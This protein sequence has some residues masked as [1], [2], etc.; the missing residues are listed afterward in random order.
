MALITLTSDLGTRDPYL[1]TVKGR[2][3]RH[4]PDLV[5]VD[6]THHVRPNEMPM[7]AWAL[8]QAYPAFAPD[9]IHWVGV[10]S[11]YVKNQRD[12]VVYHHGQYFVGPDDGLFALLFDE[13]PEFIFAIQQGI[14]SSMGLGGIYA[15]T[16]LAAAH[17][18]RGGEI[19]DIA[20]QVKG[21]AE[22]N[23]IRPHQGSD[24]IRG[25][26]I[27]VDHFGNLMLNIHRDMMEQVG[28]G[29]PMRIR[30][31]ARYQVERIRERYSDVPAGDVLARYN[32]GGYLEI[33]INRGNARDMFNL[34]LHDLVQVQFEE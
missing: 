8:R 2:L 30:F 4:S 31:R 25:T 15:D 10:D 20:E 32:S 28:R 33:A 3:Y 5:L 34:K 6:V 22:L 24:F 21:I 9:S 11:Q 16:V 18:A 7:A 27:W 13:Y 14:G 1:A 12:L 19:L 29:R 23:S 17:L 26:V